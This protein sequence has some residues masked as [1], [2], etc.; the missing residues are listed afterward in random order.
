MLA[1]FDA[2]RY[3]KLKLEIEIQA[4]V[5]PTMMQLENKS[6]VSVGRMKASQ[7]FGAKGSCRLI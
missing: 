2:S 4:N 3:P 5:K 6:K 1:V 7:G